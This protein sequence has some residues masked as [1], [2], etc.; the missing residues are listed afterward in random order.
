MHTD[1]DRPL[2]VLF[3][4]HHGEPNRGAGTVV[5]AFTSKDEAR[6]A[7]RDMR[8]SLPNRDGWAELAA[9]SGRGPAKRLSWFGQD[10]PRGRPMVTAHDRRRRWH[11][12]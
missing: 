1:D 10:D 2:Y 9:V 12:S 11:R 3:A 5:A 6:L 4:G 7:F 8:R